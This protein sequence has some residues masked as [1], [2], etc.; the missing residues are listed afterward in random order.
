MLYHNVAGIMLIPLFLL[1]LKMYKIALEYYGFLLQEKY[2]VSD[3]LR[4][5]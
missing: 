3:H 1:C 2:E 4:N 5:T